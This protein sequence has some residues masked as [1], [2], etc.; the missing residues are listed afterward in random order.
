MTNIYQKIS[1]KKI[2]FGFHFVTNPDSIFWSLKL[3]KYVD[4]E[5]NF[6]SSKN[7]IYDCRFST[8]VFL[9]CLPKI[10]YI[11]YKIKFYS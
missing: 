2:T 6:E 3:K 1:L 9:N 7:N 11:A 4:E 5:Q 8:T 10:D